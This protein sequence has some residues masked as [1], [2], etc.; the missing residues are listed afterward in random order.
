MYAK[1]EMITM[2]E[3]FDAF[4]EGLTLYAKVGNLY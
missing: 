3:K 2:S 1:H 4:N